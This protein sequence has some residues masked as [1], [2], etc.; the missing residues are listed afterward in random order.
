MTGNL[1]LRA[2]KQ[3]QKIQEQANS[4][5]LQM[6]SKIWNHVEKQETRQALDMAEKLKQFCESQIKEVSV[7]ALI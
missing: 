1:K 6:L 2:M 3:L 4:N 5:G 7:N